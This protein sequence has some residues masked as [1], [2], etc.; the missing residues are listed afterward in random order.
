MYL[1]KEIYPE[2]TKNNYVSKKTN[3]FFKKCEI[4]KTLYQKDIG[5]I[6]E[7]KI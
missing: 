5:M 1:L 6:T 3:Q 4:F 7:Q 2:H